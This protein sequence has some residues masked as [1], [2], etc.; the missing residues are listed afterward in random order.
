MKSYD[1]EKYP[2]N[3]P[4]FP[5]W[6]NIGMELEEVMAEEAD[7]RE[8]NGD[9]AYR[10]RWRELE[11]KSDIIMKDYARWRYMEMRFATP[12][13]VEPKRKCMWCEKKLEAL[14][15]DPIRKDNI[16]IREMVSQGDFH[17]MHPDCALEKLNEIRESI[18]KG[19]EKLEGMIYESHS[20][21]KNNSNY[22]ESNN[23]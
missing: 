17:S 16:I 3:E 7:Q 1:R 19:I 2:I 21:S 10:Y 6:G 5:H 12:A 13:D 15:R 18:N 8:L 9:T 22:H 14:R 20:V 4:V 23:R 11:E